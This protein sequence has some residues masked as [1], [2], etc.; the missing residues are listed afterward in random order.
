MQPDTA[1]PVVEAVLV[2][3]AMVGIG[4]ASL[5]AYM[6]ARRHA[7]GAVQEL[8][9]LTTELSNRLTTLERDRDRDYLERQAE[10]QRDYAIIAKLQRRVAD[11]EHGVERLGAQVVRLGG[12]PEWELPPAEPLPV[13]QTVIDD[14]A[15]YRS[16]AALFDVD[17]LDDLAFRLGIEPDE[18]D[19]KRRD[20]RARSLVQYCKRRDLL[21]ELI[22]IARQLRPEGRF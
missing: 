15:L 7:P 22:D 16:I 11:L 18:L 14:T 2:T 6:Q 10:R 5:W 17:E 21:P 8:V 4:F 9:Q 12:V 20:T 13:V 1:R 3:V 19:G